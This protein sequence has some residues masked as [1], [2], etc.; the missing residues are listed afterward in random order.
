MRELGARNR[1]EI[2]MWAY[3]TGRM[4]TQRAESVT[5]HDQRWPLDARSTR[6]ADPVDE[7]AR[8]GRIGPCAP[9]VDTRFVLTR[10][11]AA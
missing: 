9:T 2:A 11:S 7:H 8:M 1:V 10:R 6:H 5:G 4:D 3:E